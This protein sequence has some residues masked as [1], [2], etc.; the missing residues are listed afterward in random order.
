MLPNGS[1]FALNK[2]HMRQLSGPDTR[3]HGHGPLCRFD[4]LAS[5]GYPL[6]DGSDMKTLIAGGGILAGISSAGLVIVDKAAGFGGN[7]YWN[8]YPGVACDIE[9][10]CYIPLLEET[11]YMP[12][13]RHCH[14]HEIREHLERIAH[15]SNIQDQFCTSVT[16]K[17]WDDE[18]KTL[19]CDPE[20]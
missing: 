14:G 12:G 11:G 10:Y 13:H 6:R 7:W 17:R 4:A 9:G 8:R 1:D 20:P 18:A 19:G 2:S 15:T 3:Q 16:H 5:K